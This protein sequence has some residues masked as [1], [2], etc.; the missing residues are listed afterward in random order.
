[1]SDERI[2]VG[3]VVCLKGTRGDLAPN[4]TMT[5]DCYLAAYAPGCDRVQ[6]LWFDTTNKLYSHTFEVSAL[7]KVNCRYGQ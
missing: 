7:V 5:V 4:P 1:M 6:C 2:K 3:D